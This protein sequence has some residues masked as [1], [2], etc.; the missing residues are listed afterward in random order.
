VNGLA[1]LHAARAELR[2][3]VPDDAD[4]SIVEEWCDRYR[5]LGFDAPDA[6]IIRLAIRAYQ[7]GHVDHTAPW[8]ARRG[9]ACR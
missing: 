2:A 7:R 9:R 8:Y 6:A 1:D 4:R 3:A 5:L